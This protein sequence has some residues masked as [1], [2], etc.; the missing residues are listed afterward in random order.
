MPMGPGVIWETAT[1][2][3]NVLSL[4]QGCS[5]TTWFWIKDSIAYPPP[6]V[7]APMIKKVQA[8]WPSSASVSMSPPYNR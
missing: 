6:M 4:I 1:I 7:K 5:T 3:V 2:S 8:S